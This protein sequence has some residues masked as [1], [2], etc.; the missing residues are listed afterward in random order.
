MSLARKNPREKSKRMHTTNAS[1]GSGFAPLETPLATFG[2]AVTGSTAPGAMVGVLPTMSHDRN[3]PYR[4]KL[5]PQI[6]TTGHAD[7]KRVVF[8]KEFPSVKACHTTASPFTGEGTRHVSLTER[9]A[10]IPHS[11]TLCPHYSQI[12]SAIGTRALSAPEVDL[13]PTLEADK[14]VLRFWAYYQESIPESIEAVRIHHT[15][16][17]YYLADGS[18]DV[19]QSPEE[20]SGLMHGTLVA[21]HKV[22]KT[23]KGTGWATLNAHDLVASVTGGSEGGSGV[24]ATA[25]HEYVDWRDL[26][27]GV[28]V[29]I[30]GKIYH[31]A[32]ADEFTRRWYEERGVPQGE[33]STVSRLSRASTRS[34][35]CLFR[36]RCTHAFGCC[37]SEA[38]ISEGHGTQG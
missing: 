22:P 14:A 6:L 32:D 27:V 13:P 3:Y 18:I 28:E 30:Y 26:S 29:E 33:C 34:C 15:R 21:R 23:S 10:L 4:P 5:R 38:C 25:P 35:P 19:Q 1:Y 8:E 7:T 16:I 37:L 2:A 12:V 36:S 31:I 9:L 24:D 20:N 11:S 17:H